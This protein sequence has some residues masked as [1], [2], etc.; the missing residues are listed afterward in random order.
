MQ[1]TRVLGSSSAVTKVETV[2]IAELHEFLA[3]NTKQV[4]P[5]QM[6]LGGQKVVLRLMSKVPK[7]EEMI[8]EV[9]VCTFPECK[10][11]E[12]H[13]VSRFRFEAFVGDETS[14]ATFLIVDSVGQ[15]IAGQTAAAL[16]EIIVED[17]GAESLAFTPQCFKDL[18]GHTKKFE[19]RVIHDTQDDS[20]HD[21]IVTRI[22]PTAE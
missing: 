11:E 9:F 20:R 14:T 8:G 18:I 17:D 6:H 10:N 15:K 2:T 1:Q 4:T 5:N 12:T 22:F 3:A 13:G 16:V 19:I 7:K 21:I